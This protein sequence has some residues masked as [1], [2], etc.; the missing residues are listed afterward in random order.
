[1]ILVLQD[2]KKPIIWIHIPYEYNSRDW[3]SFGSRSSLD[4]NLPYQNLAIESIIDHNPNFHI[5]LIDD[6]SFNNLL[7][8]WTIDI[9][10]VGEPQNHNLRKLCLLKLLYNYGG[11]IVPSSFLCLQNLEVLYDLGIRNDKPF[12]VE[13]RSRIYTGQNAIEMIPDLALWEHQ[14]IIILL[15]NSVFSLKIL[16]L[17]TIQMNLTFLETLIN[18]VYKLYLQ[19]K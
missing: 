10:K 19:N 1:M 6:T 4:L 14:K 9:T 2:I 8:G 12:V 5:C 16:Y 3:S 17:Q 7:P 11:M 18:G 13:N 15:I